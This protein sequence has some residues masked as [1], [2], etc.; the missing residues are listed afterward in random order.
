MEDWNSFEE[1]EKRKEKALENHARLHKL[2]VEDRFSF[3]RERKRTIDDFID[4]V[5]DKDQR[6]NLRLL[7]G[8]WDRI[9]RNAGSRH[10]RLILAQTLFWEHFNEVFLPNIQNL[11]NVLSQGDRNPD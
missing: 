2:F 3:E 8:K 1:K 10:N 5:E 4:S 11:S 6:E 9:M 7:Q